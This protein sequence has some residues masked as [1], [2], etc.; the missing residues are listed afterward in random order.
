MQCERAVNTSRKPRSQLVPDRVTATNGECIPFPRDM[1]QPAAA[2]EPTPR[3]RVLFVS[4]AN[5]GRSPMAAA[6]L[7]SV[8]GSQFEVLS[9][10]T[11]P[12]AAL[13][14]D[15]RQVMR[16][17]GIELSYEPPR[18]LADLRGEDFDVMVV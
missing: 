8:G 7:R 9:A 2:A 18:S 3:H 1:P 6:W 17:V 12:A 10:G 14:P 15:V 5:A 11:D 16:E 4:R 13:D